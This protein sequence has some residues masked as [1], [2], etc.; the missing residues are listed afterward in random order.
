MKKM[1][2]ITLL[3]VVAIIGYSPVASAFCDY[4]QPLPQLNIEGEQFLGSWDSRRYA[5]GEV[6][7]KFFVTADGAAIITC[8]GVGGQRG[9]G[10]ST[11]IQFYG[12]NLGLQQDADGG[13]Y[14]SSAPQVGFRFSLY[15][16]EGIDGSINVSA[17][18]ASISYQLV[19]EQNVA[20][21]Y[22]LLSPGVFGVIEAYKRTEAGG[23][24]DLSLANGAD[25]IQFFIRSFDGQGSGS[26]VRRATQKR[27]LLTDVRKP[28]CEIAV[29]DLRWDNVRIKT[30]A[31]GDVLDSKQVEFVVNCDGGDPGQ[32]NI[33]I[34]SA[35]DGYNSGNSSSRL[36][37]SA[38]STAR[39]V[40]VELLRRD[41]APVRF[42]DY[43]GGAWQDSIKYTAGNH[44]IPFTVNI[45]KKSDEML[46]EGRFEFQAV[47]D[48]NYY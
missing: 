35:R 14:F 29:S 5:V 45:V 28:S 13:I 41:G 21:D 25:M 6:V 18:A 47:F 15:T 11:N 10:W 38:N 46:E 36:F 2:I 20:A 39:G 27:V 24:V 43:A 23:D 4:K 8:N 3:S 12:T 1:N 31:S 40:E 22:I 16:P 26:I 9:E 17:G 42:D 48:V 34:I 37:A 33:A 19:P 32:D 7:R 30:S 44:S